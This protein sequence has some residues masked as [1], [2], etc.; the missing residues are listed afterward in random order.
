MDQSVKR[1]GWAFSLQGE[2]H[3]EGSCNQNAVC[4]MFS[5]LLIVLQPNLILMLHHYTSEC[6]VKR[7]GLVYLQSC[8]D[9]S[10]GS[11]LCEMFVSPIFSVTTDFFATELGVL[12]YC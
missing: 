3:H 12:M 4:I 8:Q 1:K 5:E 11:K 10:K 6:L 9:H 7:L 2:G